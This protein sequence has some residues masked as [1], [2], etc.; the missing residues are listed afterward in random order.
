MKVVQR[1]SKP[2]TM[3]KL[4]NYDHLFIYFYEWEEVDSNL[5]TYLIDRLSLLMNMDDTGT[6]DYKADTHGFS[7]FVVTLYQNLTQNH[8]M[9]GK[10]QRLWIP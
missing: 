3:I 9:I 6:L 4:S 7:H 1:L 2:I 8:S 5:Y 10:G